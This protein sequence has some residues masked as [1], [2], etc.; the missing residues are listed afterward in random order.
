MSYATL[1]LMSGREWRQ[2][3]LLSLAGVYQTKREI[4]VP[5][6]LSRYLQEHP[7]VQTL[8]LHLDNDEVGRGAAAGIMGGL[9]G[10]YEVLDQPT[11]SGKDVNEFLQRRLGL[12]QRKEEWS[13]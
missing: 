3:P 2:T 4:V 9:K 13:R 11:P 5:V 6:A 12:Y 7:N 10:R 1:L 8:R